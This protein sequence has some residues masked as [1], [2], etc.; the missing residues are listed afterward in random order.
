MALLNDIQKWSETLPHWQRDAAR[1]LLLNETGLSSTDYEELYQ[2][3]KAEHGLPVAEGLTAIPL[4]TEHLPAELAD[5]ETVNLKALRNLQHVNK[6][7]AGEVLNFQAKGMTIVYGGNGSGK[8][9]YTRV[10][11]RACRARDQAEPIHPDAT[12]PAEADE[13]PSATF[14][15]EVSGEAEEVSWSCESIP[16]DK[17]SNIAVFD[18]RCAR[19][20]LTAEQDV[21]YLPY[22][23]DIVENLANAVLP[24]LKE[25]LGAEIAGIDVNTAPYAHLLGETAVGRQFE[26]L[27]AKSSRETIQELGTLGDEDLVRF[28]D[29]TKA[30]AEKDPV[31]KARELKL[32]AERLKA[33]AGKMNKPLAWVCDDAVEKLRSLVQSKLESEDAET[34]AAEVLQAGETLLPGTG[35]QMW[36][37]LFESARRYSTEVAY[38]RYDY[39]KT[40]DGAV[41]PLCQEELSG[42]A[43]ERLI[44]F[45]QYVKDDVAKIAGEKRQKLNEAKQK[46]EEAELKFGDDAV[47]EEI[48]QLDDSLPAIITSYE[49]GLQ[50]RKQAMLNC[51]TTNDWAEIPE[52]HEDPRVRIRNL[53]AGQLRSSRTLKRAADEEKKRLLVAEHAELAARIELSKSLDSVL[54][55]LERMKNKVA[56]DACYDQLKTRPISDQSKAFT[57]QAVTRELKIAL[58][59]EFKVLGVGHI[60]TKLKERSDRGK[61]LHQLLLDL[62]TARKV[63]EI[64][65]EGEQRAI[66]VGSFL[67]E[68]TLANH[69][70]GIVFDDPVSSLDHMRRNR[71]ARRLAIESANRQV[72]IFTHDT[73]FLHQLRHECSQ[74]GTDPLISSLEWEGTCSGKVHTGLP[75]GHKSVADRID[76]IEKKQRYL[77]KLPWPAYPSEEV[78]GQIIRLYS[79][80]RATIE[81]FVQDI[82]LNG[83]VQRYRDYV[84]VK[85]LDRVIG[86]QQNEVD[87]IFRLTQRC[88]DIVEAHDPSSAKDDPPPT[89]DELKQ[90]ID[91]LKSLIEQ[92]KHRRRTC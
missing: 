30:L 33:Y 35:Q 66:A 58:D 22:G 7:G 77:E 12:N 63:D 68:L 23:L 10:M 88:H 91:D 1:R 82:V 64:L 9:G 44:R 46:I 92:I 78:A 48:R 11:K 70:C 25:K 15:I 36:K 49:E 53:A 27:N 28:D 85:R 52:L 32:S 83:T 79:F 2:L 74:L 16:P 81:R 80:L 71:V 41:C 60:N 43:S 26:G 84:E 47:L 87:E 65:S 90:D 5:G 38:P 18:S 55:L 57:S 51:I 62:P 89:P 75:W 72:I 19:S 50:N 56:L 45:E 69:A 59:R 6:I 67:A 4:A 17:L 76:R 40:G 8:S 20:Y 13:T 31:A 39:P 14:D 61:T 34:R 73:V 24:E 37:A 42:T 21:A 3:L 54:A 86:L 29:L